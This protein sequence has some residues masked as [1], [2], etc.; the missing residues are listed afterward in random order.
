M[1]QL[2]EQMKGKEREQPGEKHIPGN[3]LALETR[4]K[5][6]DA[7]TKMATDKVNYWGEQ[8]KGFNEKMN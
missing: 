1:K 4:K 7:V 6:V 8:R 2:V 5:V 3:A